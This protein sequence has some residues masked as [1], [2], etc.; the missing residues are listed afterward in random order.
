VSD[1]FAPGATVCNLATVTCNVPGLPAL[2]AQTAEAVCPVSE[3]GCLTRTPGFWKSHVNVVNAVI[4]VTS[5]GIDLTTHNAGFEGSTS[6]DLCI[7]NQEAKYGVDQTGGTSSQQFQL[8]RQ[9]AAAALNLQ[10]SLQLE[11]SCSTAAIDGAI[12]FADIQA[13][14]DTCC[15]VGVP[16]DGAGFVRGICNS[17]K[18]VA[19]INA[20]GCIGYLDNFNNANFNEGDG[21]DS[22]ADLDPN[23][24][25]VNTAQCDIADA[26]LRLNDRNQNDGRQYGP[27]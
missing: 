6:E 12:P 21:E 3:G 14:F 11:L 7:N 19:Q 22:L 15:G 17:D 10:A 18:T 4:P 16:A 13:R 24:N 26:N 23:W 9:C 20:S 27:K 25:D 5:C 1:P 8:V 2:D